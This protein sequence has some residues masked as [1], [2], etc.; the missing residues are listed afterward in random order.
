VAHPSDKDPLANVR[1]HK[2]E[3]PIRL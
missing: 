1:R 3:R 2:R